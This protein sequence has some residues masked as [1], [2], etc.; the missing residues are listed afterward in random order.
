[1]YHPFHSSVANVVLRRLRE[2]IVAKPRAAAVLYCHPTLQSPLASELFEA[3]SVF[4]RTAHGA[5]N[6]R[7]FEL[8]WSVFTNAA[9]MERT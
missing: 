2:S 4:R 9:W 5:R 7:S 6:T 8:G 3:G 1:M